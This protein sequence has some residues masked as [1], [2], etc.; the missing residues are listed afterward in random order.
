[1]ASDAPEISL[2]PSIA[3]IP[4][5]EWDACAGTGN[6]FVSHAFL[7]A[8]EETGCVGGRTGWTPQH[9]VAR[10]A[11]GAPI[12]VAPLYAKTHSYGEYVFDHG[13]AN[14]YERAGGAYYPKLQSCVPFT[15]VTGPRLLLHPDAPADGA[16]VLV[17]GLEAA[18][19]QTG[20]SSLHVTFPTESE[21]SMLGEA[22]WLLRTGQQYHWEN[23]GYRCFDDF[24]GELNS[25]K[26]KSIRRERREVA[27]AGVEVLALSG[28]DLRPE[29]WDAFHRFYMDTAGRKWGQ[30]YLNRAFFHRIGETM[31]DR[32]VL[33]LGRRG[34]EW[35]C[36]ALNLV[37]G[38]AL[39]GRNWGAV[40]DVPFLHFEAC[41]YRAMDVAIERGL[42]R[43]EA[44]AQGE[45]KIQ[46]GYLPT[47][48]RSAHWVA[49]PGFR[50]AIAD[51]LERERTAVDRD[52]ELLAEYAPFRQG[53][54]TEDQE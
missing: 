15:P 4:A 12:G 19:R 20:V 50:R 34:G 26:R 8:L 23:R 44:G 51:Y 40:V 9:L 16:A 38:D 21:W 29:H 22:G 5:A 31:A 48:T 18:A 49:D 2:V 28:G 25:R 47:R 35:I 32:I 54:P 42:A 1:M 27:D 43:V 17:A 6:P 52:M 33:M 53:V 7:S 45:H 41:Y 24:L 14:A 10:T 36:G 37:G 30:P 13:W 46:R 3:R 39:Y 11:A